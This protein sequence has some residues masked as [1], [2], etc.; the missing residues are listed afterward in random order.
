MIAGRQAQARL[1]KNPSTSPR[2]G[3]V[4]LMVVG[5]LFEAKTTV[6]AWSWSRPV[7]VDPDL[8][9][10]K[11]SSSSVTNGPSSLNHVHRHIINELHRAQRIRLE[12]HVSLLETRT[13]SPSW[14]WVLR[15][16]PCPGVVGRLRGWCDGGCSSNRGGCRL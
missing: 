4:Q 7:K 13:G 11:S 12:R 6:A 10:S 14:A 16:R 8:G 2:I 5:S 1:R 15:R 9:M 3:Q